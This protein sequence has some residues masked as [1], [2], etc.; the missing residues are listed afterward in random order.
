MRRH[1]WCYQGYSIPKAGRFLD[2]GETALRRWIQQ[3]KLERDGGTPVSKALTAEQRRIQ[4]LEARVHRLEW[5]KVILK[6][7]TALLMPDQMNRT[8]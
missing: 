2:I 8:P 6:M 5:E 3:L 4:E 1:A 7:A